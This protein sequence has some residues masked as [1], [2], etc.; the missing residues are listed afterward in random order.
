[1]TKPLKGVLWV[2]YNNNPIKNFFS[3]YPRLNKKGSN[4]S[5]KVLGKENLREKEKKPW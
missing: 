1:M 2:L 3:G 4:F 5:G